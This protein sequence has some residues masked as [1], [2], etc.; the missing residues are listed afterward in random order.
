[1]LFLRETN[2]KGLLLSV[3]Q[4]VVKCIWECNQSGRSVVFNPEPI[5]MSTTSCV[6]CSISMILL[7]QWPCLIKVITL[8]TES[9][10]Y[11]ALVLKKKQSL[12]EI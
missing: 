2:S 7:F 12:Y 5:A 3:G 9:L 4:I 6:F 8:W 10:F 11:E 1:M